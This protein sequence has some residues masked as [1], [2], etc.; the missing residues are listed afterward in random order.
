M[1][2]IYPKLTHEDV[3]NLTEFFNYV[4]DNHDGF[5]TIEEI[6]KACA[7]DIDGDGTITETEMLKCAQVWLDSYMKLQDINFDSKLTLD[8]ILK[9]NNDTKM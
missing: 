3:L 5:I 7:V 9:Y 8:E 6:K 2:A 1:S 4:D